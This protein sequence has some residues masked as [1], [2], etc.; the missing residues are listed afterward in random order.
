MQKAT[1]TQIKLMQKACL[2]CDKSKCGYKIGCIAVKDGKVLVQ[3][4]NES[5]PGESYCQNGACYRE[6]HGFRGGKELEKVCAIHAEASI[7][8]QAAAKG[9]RLLGCDVYV[10]TFPCLICARLLCKA[11]VGRIFYMSD[12]MGG[13]DCMDLFDS[14]GVGVTQILENEVWQETKNLA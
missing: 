14:N 4:F 10:T 1:T 9:V 13:N 6:Q 7:V 12:Y 2:L 11:N 8:A 3:A 5:L